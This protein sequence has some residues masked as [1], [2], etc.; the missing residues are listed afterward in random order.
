M[1][2]LFSPFYLFDGS[3]SFFTKLIIVF[4]ENELTESFR[5]VNLSYIKLFQK[6]AKSRN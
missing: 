5:E 4:I 2:K 6:K 1:I 3:L